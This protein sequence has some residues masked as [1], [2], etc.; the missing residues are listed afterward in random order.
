MGKSDNSIIIMVIFV[1]VVVA[2]VIPSKSILVLSVKISGDTP[3]HV[4]FLQ[5][6]IAYIPF[7]L[8]RES[9]SNTIGNIE[10]VVNTT[11]PATNV[12]DTKTYY[13]SD[14]DFLIKTYMKIEKGYGVTVYFP[15]YNYERSIT[16]G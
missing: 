1:I 9:K 2:L 11:N 4:T 6:K 13:L 5:E 7:V 12:T 8:N 14:G 3:I 15:Q 16:V 10:M